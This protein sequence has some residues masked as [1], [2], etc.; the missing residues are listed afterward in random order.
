MPPSPISLL[1][2][3]PAARKLGLGRFAF[4]SMGT[5][6][7]VLARL[8]R[9]GEAGAAVQ[10]LFTRWDDTLS[11]FK[12]ESELSRLNA[13]PGTW[14]VCSPLLL[15]VLEASLDWARR[16][17][18]SFDPAVGA[19]MVAAG[20]DRTFSGLPADRPAAAPRPAG[21]WRAIAIDRDRVRLPEGAE[22]DFGGIAKGMAVDAAMA[23]LGGL[24]LDCVAVDAGGDLR[25]AGLPP[26][27]SSWTIAVETPG[28]DVN[29]ALAA[30]ALAT[31]SV[32][33]R[34][35]RMGGEEM[36]HLL[37]P[38]TGRPAAAGVLSVTVAAPRCEEAEVAAKT[39]LL[40]GDRAGRLHLE[41]LGFDGLIS[42]D[43]GGSIRAGNWPQP[44]VELPGQGEGPS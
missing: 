15:H 41:S 6:V 5:E 4:A 37:D 17:G 18:G 1:S 42:L 24:G 3:E 7:A 28:G 16:T 29:I 14:F 21:G 26:G 2:S 23:E 44:E 22:L 11:R 19:S 35:W 9:E 32:L 13:V 25:V 8:G 34:R 27:E 39:A 20:Y 40:L 33:G 38:K 30:G 36:H 12:P 10:Q 43:G 31:S